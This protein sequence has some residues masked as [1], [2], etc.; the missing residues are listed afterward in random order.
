M[1]ELAAAPDTVPAY[2][3]YDTENTLIG[4][5][6]Q[7]PSGSVMAYGHDFEAQPLADGFLD[8]YLDTCDDFDSAKKTIAAYIDEWMTHAPAE[9][10]E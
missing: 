7:L 6:I 8:F 5:A 10:T 4:L 1:P 3:Y 2:R 9:V